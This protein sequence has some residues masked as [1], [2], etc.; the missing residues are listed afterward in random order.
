MVRFSK[1]LQGIPWALIQP[2]QEI[3]LVQDTTQTSEITV[4]TISNH[5]MAILYI[6]TAREFSLDLTK[7]TGNSFRAVWYSPRTGRRWTGGE[8]DRT[9]TAL[10]VPPDKQ[11]DWDWILLVGSKN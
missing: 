8:F 11:P 6:P 1:I 10:I 3:K 5:R 9:D 2:D 7:L 4:A